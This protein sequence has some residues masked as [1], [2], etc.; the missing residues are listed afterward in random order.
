MERFEHGGDIYSR[1][2]AYDFSANINPLGL[3]G[4]VRK[5]LISHVDDSVHYPDVSAAGLRAAIAE[6]EGMRAGQVVCGNG[7][8]DLIYRIVWTLKPQKALLLAPTFSEYERALRSVGCDV[9]FHMLREEEAFALREDFLDKIDGNDMIFLCNPNNPTGRTIPGELMSRIAARC[10]KSGCVLVVDA[11]F[12]DFVEKESSVTEKGRFVENAIILKAFTKF[13]AMP[14]LRLGYVLCE[15]EVLAERIRSCGQC[16]AVSVPAQVAGMAA[17]RETEYVEATLKLIPKEREYLF[18]AL[19]GLGM[20][21]YPSEA[22]FLLFRCDRPLDRLLLKEGIAIRSCENYEGLEY[23]F[24]RIAV[25]SH[26]ENE[27]LI[28]AIERVL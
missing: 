4:G 17:L 12:W 15:D 6:H 27:I 21:V 1:Q 10:R 8:A 20:K 5:A 14:G 19:T 24:F 23:G 3:P 11:C 18:E 26:D 7:A 28:R 2:I 25:R 9:G 16:W 13:Y 22:N